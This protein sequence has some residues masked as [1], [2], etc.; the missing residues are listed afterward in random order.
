MGDDKFSQSWT[1]YLALAVNVL[2][3]T[4]KIQHITKGD[5]SKSASLRVMKKYDESSLM[6]MLQEFGTL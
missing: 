4:P 2:R 5:V 6:Q 1:G 3:N